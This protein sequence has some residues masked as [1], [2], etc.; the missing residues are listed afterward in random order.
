MTENVVIEHMRRLGLV[1]R[2]DFP[3]QAAGFV[4]DSL[5]SLGKG[6]RLQ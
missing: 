1:A 2:K 3:I 4:G 6:C 5:G